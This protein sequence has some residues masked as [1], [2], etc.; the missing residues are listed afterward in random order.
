[1]WLSVVHG[2]MGI[3]YFAHEWVPRFRE[4]A[5]L[6]YPDIRDAVRSVNSEIRD[7]APVL[8]GE[9]LAYGDEIPG[10]GGERVSAPGADGTH[11]WAAN[12]SA[13][14]ADVGQ[15][16]APPLE[17]EPADPGVRV[18]AMVKRHAGWIYVVAVVPGEQPTTVTFHP[19]PALVAGAA[20]GAV[21]VEVI[22][23]GR[24]LPL[25]AGAFE[26]AFDG[27]GVHRYRLRARSDEG[28]GGAGDPQ[29][30]PIFLPRGL[31]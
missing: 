8:N 6:D 20:D 12:A 11:G 9:T 21:E 19:D 23:E 1:V 14:S 16:A 27:Y 4:P 25:R 24:V 18:D 10:S 30:R 5:L 22:G 15:A 2:S 7:L 3:V 13:R 26:D 17:V 31:R 29:L 28:G